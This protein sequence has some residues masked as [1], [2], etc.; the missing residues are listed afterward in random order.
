M[1][2]SEA[3]RGELARRGIAY[4]V[5]AFL[6]SAE[7]GNVTVVKLF[8]EAGML[9]NTANKDGLTALHRAARAGHLELVQ[10]L[11]AQG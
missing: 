6:G 4:T 11:V 10:Y 2:L 8:V 9:V 7:K 1:S 3:A 5:S